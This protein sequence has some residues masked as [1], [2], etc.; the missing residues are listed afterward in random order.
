MQDCIEEA[1]KNGP[2]SLSCDLLHAAF[3]CVEDHSYL[4]L[5]ISNLSDEPDFVVSGLAP[6]ML[7]EFLVGVE[8]DN[9]LLALVGA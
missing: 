5:S 3:F 1:W 6:H 7:P 8:G 2:L 4:F 9:V